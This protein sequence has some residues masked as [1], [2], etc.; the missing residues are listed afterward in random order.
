MDYCFCIYIFI[1]SSIWWKDYS[2]STELPVHNCRKLYI[3]KYVGLFLNSL[4]CSINLF[5]CQYSVQFSGSVVSDSL[6]CS[7]PGLPVHQQLP[8]LTQI[9]VHGVGDAI[10]PS[11][12][13]LSPSP[14][15]FNLS[16]HQGL[17]QW[18]SLVISYLIL[19]FFKL[20][21]VIL[22]PLHFCIS[23]WNKCISI[24]KETCWD[25]DWDCMEFIDQI[26]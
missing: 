8:E 15:A 23:F 9:H 7:T 5:L 2:F 17:F 11:H 25:F 3:H 14:P 26:W 1:W 6:D 22:C 16:Q 4:F 19:F 10:Q 21:L 24:Y 13:L 18:V 12:P 20:V